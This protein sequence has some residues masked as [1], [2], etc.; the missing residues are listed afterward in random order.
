MLDIIMTST[1][2]GC[3][4]ALNTVPKTLFICNK[5]KLLS[6]VTWILFIKS[7]SLIMRTTCNGETWNQKIKV[8]VI[9]L[10]LT[11]MMMGKTWTFDF[12]FSCLIE[13]IILCVLYIIGLF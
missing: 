6:I 8:G 1:K 7:R 9:A 10:S 2:W 11:G 4:E 5:L 13:V 3:S 12:V